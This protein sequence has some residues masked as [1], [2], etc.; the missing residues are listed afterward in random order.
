MVRKV[1]VA[2]KPFFS[3]LQLAFSIL[4]GSV[5]VLLPQ[6][7]AQAPTSVTAAKI[8]IDPRD[9]LN[10]KADAKLTVTFTP[11]T[12]IPDG[13][14]IYLAV[15]YGSSSFYQINPGGSSPATM[16]SC[17]V[18]PQ[19]S[20]TFQSSVNDGQFQNRNVI[21]IRISGASIP[22]SQA[23]TMTI[24]NLFVNNLPADSSSRS[25]NSLMIS[26]SVDTNFVSFPGSL[27]GNTH[28]Q[29]SATTLSQVSVTI[30]NSDRVYSASAAVTIKFT[31]ST[32]LVA[33]SDSWGNA[34]VLWFPKGFFR[35]QSASLTFKSS[36]SN[37][38]LET[39]ANGLT[40]EY[41]AIRNVGG[42]SESPTGAPIPANSPCTITISG[43][44]LNSPVGNIPN[45]MMIT[46]SRDSA[47]NMAVDSGYI[48]IGSYVNGSCP[49]GMTWSNA[50]KACTSCS[51]SFSPR[52]LGAGG[53]YYS[54]P[55]GLICDNFSDCFSCVACPGSQAVSSSTSS[56]PQ[57]YAPSIMGP[58]AA[59]VFYAC[60]NSTT[61]C[62][63]GSGKLYG[64]NGGC[65]P[66]P[67]DMYNDGSSDRCQYC[68][69][70][71]YPT[72]SVMKTSVQINCLNC[73][74]TASA[75]AT[76]TVQTGHVMKKSASSCSSRCPP[77]TGVLSDPARFSMSHNLGRKLLYLWG[78]LEKV[79]NADP[80]LTPKAN[81]GCFPCTNWFISKDN[82]C[83][84]CNV[85]ASDRASLNTMGDSYAFASR[86]I[87]DICPWPYVVPN[88]ESLQMLDAASIDAPPSASLELCKMTVH[89]GGTQATI[90]VIAV[91]LLG[92][93]AVSISFAALGQDE[94][95][96]AARRRKLV[97][98][99]LMTTLSPAIDF[100]SDLM[101]IVSTL[102]YNDII[103]I[104]CCAFY[105]LPMFFFWRMLVK[106]GVHFSFYIGKPPAF[107]VMEKYDSI[108]KA[109]LGFVGY[110][111][112]YIINL[113]VSLPLF[114]VGH[115]LYCCKVFPISRVSNLWLRLYS[116]SEKHTSSVNIIIPLLQESIF[117]EM[118]TESVPQ[119]AIQI[120]NNTF[121]AVWSPLSYFSTAMSA[122]MI[123]N[124]I[125]RLVYY[126]LYLKIK[127][128]A[129]PSDLSNDVFNFASIKE[130]ESPLGRSLDAKVAPVLEMSTI[131]SA[132][133]RPAPVF[134]T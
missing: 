70:G 92:I 40:A 96:T 63:A 109:I 68:P 23:F 106:H 25:S 6:V 66:C 111:P 89:L 52:S 58:P 46:T 119:M 34:I 123:L 86:C 71:T 87:P 102:F 9:L 48:G 51:N 21:K 114:L 88:L 103:C 108:P 110:F 39:M 8:T 32:V 35:T 112:L 121:T 98:G 115:V 113:P 85:G 12:T 129:I 45:S 16:L 131:V 1:L 95:L 118:L 117:E 79:F 75:S 47:A 43:L 107:A 30:A 41:L 53:G 84:A 3:I 27:P 4:A 64:D 5:L 69:S 127:I 18:C 83:Q 62:P 125:W 20:A 134:C 94:A 60:S 22:S 105:L 55:T 24:G 77:F 99:M 65:S 97:L 76:A 126:R 116:R 72:Y 73:G 2:M 100:I 31:P 50:D 36:V 59:L 104:V 15:G 10:N 80:P 37:A 61:R 90:S 56:G 33:T 38:Y 17:S 128:N 11:T 124:G 57:G 13:G 44:I 81:S 14:Y 122:A 49:Y 132:V 28:Y 74:L 101:Y 7:E 29:S 82:T 26:T 91:I 120:V 133:C 78:S 130:G 93:Y 54:T 42:R 67:Y 19:L